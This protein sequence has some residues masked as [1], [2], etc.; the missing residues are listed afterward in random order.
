MFERWLQTG[1]TDDAQV[2]DGQHDNEKDELLH[3]ESSEHEQHFHV[4]AKGKDQSTISEKEKEQGQKDEERKKE[5]K[6]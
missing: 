2:R 5:K 3:K 1:Q 4:E 6:R